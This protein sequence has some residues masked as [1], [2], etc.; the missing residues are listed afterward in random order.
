MALTINSNILSLNAQQ[1]FNAHSKNLE[2]TYTKLSSGLR[3][4]KASDDAA[5]LSISSLLTADKRVTNQGTR[6]IN[7]GVSYLN[8]AEG[9]INELTNIVTRIGELAEQGANGT[10][11]SKQRE[12]LQNEVTSLEAEYNRIIK[13][14]SFNGNTLLTGITTNTKLQGGYGT[15]GQLT[16]QVGETSLGISGDETRAGL[17]T[18]VDT[19]SDGTGGNG[20]S[21]TSVISASGR[22]LAFTSGSTNLI[23]NDTNG[24]SDVFIKDLITGETKIV[25]TSSSGTQGNAASFVNNISGD[26]RYVLFSTQSS[27]L[28]TG[29]TNGAADIFIKD[30]LTGET[31]AVSTSSSG[32]FGNGTAVTG[33]LSADA[34]F[35]TFT[36]NASNLASGDT[37]GF[38][39]VFVKD[40]TTGE[41]KLVSTD[42]SGNLSNGMALVSAISGD[43]R[44]VAFNSTASNLVSGDTNGLTD[45]FVK[46][47]STGITTR[48]STDSSGNESNAAII[49]SNL[50]ISADGRYV[51]FDTSATN[52]VSND[53]NAVA[54][55]FVK[56]RQTG[57]T[58]RAT[59][60]SNGNQADFSSASKSLSSDGRYI[61]F[62]SSASN[63]VSNDTNAAVD[64]F[65]KDLISGETRR[66]SLDNSGNQSSGTN[67]SSSISYDGRYASFYDSAI[68]QVFVRDL[69]I[70]GI[71]EIAGMLVSNQGSAKI[72]VDLSKKYIEDLSKY[73]AQI[74]ASLSRAS[75]FL[76]TL[77]VQSENY[78]SAASQITDADIAE[79]AAN[80]TK[81]QI[82]Q[83][84]AGSILAQ[85]NQQPQLALRLLSGI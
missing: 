12:A 74:G 71:N 2:N 31:S 72:T 8:V 44:Y 40:L 47:L 68:N 43:G 30:T 59:T 34:K 9:A 14:T 6:N 1:R 20:A 61:L 18:R 3:I 36:S 76:N 64:V 67:F 42:S 38:Y 13:T 24:V 16:V 25:S 60:D 5:G 11:G 73:K 51:A 27:N 19:A 84:A 63:L 80:L 75:T 52:L 17:T 85:A 78:T 26:G 53:T 49:T 22:Y 41:T 58:I 62:H 45:T 57:Q 83:Q 69:S 65:V 81:T 37:N 33:A 15:Q 70:A 7:D 50:S 77:Q 28:V 10:L 35:V 39:D 66:V 4:N 21:T 54:D 82:L 48:V 46:D 79:E 29:D 55:T 23:S 56:D 32:T